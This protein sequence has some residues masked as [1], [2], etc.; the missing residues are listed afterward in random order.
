MTLL[1]SF[2]NYKANEGSGEPS[3]IGVLFQNDCRPGWQKLMKTTIELNPL[4]AFLR[5]SRSRRNDSKIIQ[6]QDI[7]ESYNLARII[8]TDF[9]LLKKINALRSFDVQRNMPVLLDFL[10]KR[11]GPE[12]LS[13]VLGGSYRIVNP[14]CW[15]FPHSRGGRQGIGWVAQELLDIGLKGTILIQKDCNETLMVNMTKR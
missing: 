9:A 12:Y 3:A 13:R 4:C 15:R 10:K 11:Y 7:T 2:P 14:I 8:K 5:W 6:L 1:E